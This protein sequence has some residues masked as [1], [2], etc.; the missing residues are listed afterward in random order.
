MC[1]KIVKVLE[2]GQSYF[3]AVLPVVGVGVFNRGW[4][5]GGGG[6]IPINPSKMTMSDK[7]NI[8]DLYC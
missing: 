3:V 1:Y 8:T 7:L 6:G 5:G 2:D 4:G